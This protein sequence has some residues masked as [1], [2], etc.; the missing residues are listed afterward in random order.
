MDAAANRISPA[1][2][3]ADATDPEADA[4]RVEDRVLVALTALFALLMAGM[5]GAAINLLLLASR[6]E[7]QVLVLPVQGL[8]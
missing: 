7:G 8:Y 4:F 2:A 6:A 1:S 5:A 3:D